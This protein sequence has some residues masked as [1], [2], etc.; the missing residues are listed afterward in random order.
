[1]KAAVLHELGKAPRYAEFAEPVA[2]EGEAL[3]R[4]RAASLKGVDRQLASGAHYASPREFPVVCGTDGVGELEDGTRVFF[5]GPRRPFGAMAERTVV[6]RAFCFAV[7]PELSD[8]SAAALPNP[9]VSA[10][11]T[12]TQRAKLVAGETVLILGATGVTGQ[13]AVQIAKLLG[14]KRVIGAGRNE[15]ALARLRELGADVTIPLAQET[16]ALVEEFRRNAGEEG[17]DV[18]IDYLWGKP[19]EALLAAM[20]K[21]EFAVIK[22]ETRLVQVG[23][24]AGATIALPAAVLRSTAL[25]ISG[26]AGI[27]SREIL[28]DAMQQVLTR[29]ARGELK[30]ETD[31]VALAEFEKVWERKVESGRRVVVAV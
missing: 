3:V 24:S 17:F 9:G 31:R 21:S 5:G 15:S 19:T 12:L 7:P 29:G 13:L 1:M 22:K 23:E 28:M 16:D 20:A 2:G 30:I 18:V 26:T 11:L 10:W 4:V 25:T 27:P 14:A 8:E 6:P